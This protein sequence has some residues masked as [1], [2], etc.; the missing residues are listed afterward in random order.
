MARFYHNE[1]PNTL[2][3]ESQRYNVVGSD[4]KAMGHNVISTNGAPLGGY[5]A[6]LFTRDPAAPV[7]EGSGGFDKKEFGK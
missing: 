3:L 1:V 5:Q 6:I 7:P 4:L 2:A